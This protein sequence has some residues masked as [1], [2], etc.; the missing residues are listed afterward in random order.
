MKKIL[1][2]TRPISPPWDEASKNFA[3]Y[4]AKNLDSFDFTLLTNGNI[5]DMPKHITQNPVYNSN[6]LSLW[7][8]IK[9]LKLFRIKNDFDIIH[10]M[11]TPTR[12]NALTF[13]ALL[14]GKAK[15]IQTVA[16]LREDLFSEADFKHMLFANLIVT[17]SDYA[18]NTLAAMGFSNIERIYPGI[19]IE[20]YRY[21]PKHLAT[22]AMFGLSEKYFNIVYPGEYSRLGATDMIIEA[23]PKILDGI[24]NAKLIF[25]CRIKNSADASKKDEV[26]SKLTKMGLIDRV[27][28]TDT[29]DDMPKLYNISDIIIFPVE[30]MNGK[31]DIPLAVVESMACEKPVI[32]SDIPILQELSKEENSVRIKKG[33]V[34]QL[35]SAILDLYNNPEKR[36]SM[37]KSSR[38]FVEE[39][40]DIRNIAEKYKT[41][42]E[43]L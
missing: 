6:R 7:Q 34:E 39:N 41:I 25:A 37:G 21:A 38:K 31:F 18:K 27:V 35:N 36:S 29:F 5:P 30:N 2:V 10:F 23:L 42:Y 14:G 9:L 3:Y 17:Y 8:K 11:L 26:V 28:F 20:K 13:K 33:N 40:F 15:T 19:D 12:F 22:L 1:L 43:K 32:T 24:P 4:L 16:T